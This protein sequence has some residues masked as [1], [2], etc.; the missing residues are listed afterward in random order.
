WADED[1]GPYTDIDFVGAGVLTGPFPSTYNRHFDF[2]ET[3]VFLPPAFLDK[4]GPVFYD[5]QTNT[6]NA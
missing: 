2:Y 6:W 5:E 3:G 1:I 4:W